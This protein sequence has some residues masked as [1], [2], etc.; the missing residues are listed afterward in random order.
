LKLQLG[1]GA[2]REEKLKAEI[3]K[4]KLQFRAGAHFEEKQ[5]AE[6]WGRKADEEKLKAEIGTR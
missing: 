3:G 5:K 2:H 6:S 1:A 4:L